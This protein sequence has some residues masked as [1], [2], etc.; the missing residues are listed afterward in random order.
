MVGINFYDV[1]LGDSDG[2]TTVEAIVQ[3][4]LHVSD[5]AGIEAIAFGSD[6]DG[7]ESRLEFLDYSGMP[8]ILSALEKHFTED[9]I[10]KI[11]SGNFLRV[12]AEQV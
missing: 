11:R 10:D 7:I 4:M 2:F 8:K 6:F 1:F 12:F 3:H 5:K 9:E